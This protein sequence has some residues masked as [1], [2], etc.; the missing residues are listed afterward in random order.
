MN[1]ADPL[2]RFT[3]SV[4]AWLLDRAREL[5]ITPQELSD[6]YEIRYVSSAP[7]QEGVAAYRAV[8]TLHLERRSAL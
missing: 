4:D 8:L 1:T 2:A 6:Q 3:D 7:I 5:G